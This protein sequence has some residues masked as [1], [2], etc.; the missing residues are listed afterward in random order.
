MEEAHICVRGTVAEP[1]RRFSVHYGNPGRR[2]L[3][4]GDVIQRFLN[5]SSQHR[6]YLPLAIMAAILFLYTLPTALELIALQF[7]NVW[8][9]C[10]L[11]GDLAGCIC[12][13][14]VF[15]RPRTA[16]MLYVLLTAIEGSLHLTNLVPASA[17]VWIVD[18]VPTIVVA[19]LTFQTTKTTGLRNA[20]IS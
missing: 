11:P 12:I 10:I 17:F 5:V 3:E 6:M 20:V 1:Q 19:A 14:T 8:V 16:V 2:T 18:L 13:A 15:Q 9:A 7:T 4:A